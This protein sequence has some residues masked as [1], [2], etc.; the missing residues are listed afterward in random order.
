MPDW[1]NIFPKKESEE[2]N[3]VGYQLENVDGVPFFIIFQ[4][5]KLYAYVNSCPHTGAP[6]EWVENQFLSLDNNF[7]E[8]SLHGA[9]FDIK[10][11]TC[12]HGPCIGDQLISLPVRKTG[13]DF[14]V[15]IEQL[16]T[17]HST[18]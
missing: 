11:G 4:E 2:I 1:I 8:C 13:K 12:L 18:G 15:D 5:E 17:I 14:Q 7:I 3:S 6:L 9:L 16:K 10:S